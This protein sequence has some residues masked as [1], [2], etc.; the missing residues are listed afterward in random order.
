MPL[1][2]AKPDRRI[3]ELLKTTDLENLTFSDFQNV[4]KTVYAE[5]GAEDTLRRIVLVNLARMSVAGQWDGLTSAGGGGAGFPSLSIDDDDAAD[6]YNIAA[7]TPY[8]IQGTAA[9]SLGTVDNNPFFYPFVSPK[10]GDLARMT[11]SVRVA[12]SGENFLVGVYSEDENGYF[13][14]TLLGS[15]TF[16]LNATGEVSQTSFSS[17]ITLE[18][19]K[20]YWIGWVGDTSGSSGQV[21]AQ[22]NSNPGFGGATDSLTGT[23]PAFRHVSTTSSLPSSISNVSELYLDTGKRACVGMKW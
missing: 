21:W 11:V 20:K 7:F 6:D 13:P 16:S 4:A 15:A 17:T 8:G 18:A 14:K 2:D 1:P 9:Q 23:R 3:Y 5:Q 22:S 19:G 10:S 12:A